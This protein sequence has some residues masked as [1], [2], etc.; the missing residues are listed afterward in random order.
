M[1]AEKDEDDDEDGALSRRESRSL[2][3]TL[4]VACQLLWLDGGGSRCC[5]DADDDDDDDLRVRLLDNED[6]KD[7]DE[8]DDDVEEE[9]EEPPFARDAKD[10][11]N[12]LCSASIISE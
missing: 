4:R 1:G 7:D 11:I 5:D 10:K 2:V 12:L 6:L 3:Y 9:L 8:D